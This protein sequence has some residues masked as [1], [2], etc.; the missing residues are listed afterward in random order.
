MRKVIDCNSLIFYGLCK[1]SITELASNNFIKTRMKKE[2][3][4]FYLYILSHFNSLIEIGKRWVN[5]K[6]VILDRFC[7]RDFKA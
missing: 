4:C 7:F 6:F 1:G 2:V 5:Q 3:Y